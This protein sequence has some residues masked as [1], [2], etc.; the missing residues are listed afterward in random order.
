[1]GFQEALLKF[2]QEDNL[3][4]NQISNEDGMRFSVDCER[5]RIDP[6]DSFM[7]KAKM[8]VVRICKNN[9]KAKNICI[10]LEYLSF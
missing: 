8:S 5:D 6:S 9:Q 3:C 2:G 7:E 4:H 10:E 1:M